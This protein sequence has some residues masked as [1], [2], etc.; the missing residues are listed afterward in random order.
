VIED[1]PV[2]IEA[3]KGAGTKSIGICLYQTRDAL[4]AADLVIDK[5]ADL[6]AD[7]VCDLVE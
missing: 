7:A 1:A 2:G 3:A 6:T 4:G 5:L